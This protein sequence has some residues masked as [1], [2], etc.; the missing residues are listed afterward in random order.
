MSKRRP[1]MIAGFTLIEVIATLVIFSFAGLIAAT[2]LGAGYLRVEQIVTQQEDVRDVASCVERIKAEYAG[3]KVSSIDEDSIK[4]VCGLD[5]SV[6]S[7]GIDVN[8]TTTSDKYKEVTLVKCGEETGVACSLWFI[9]VSRGGVKF[10]YV[11]R[12]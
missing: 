3:Q 6:Q 5:I 9:S 11:L 10:D 2:V 1:F 4:R 12:Q 8:T 7:V